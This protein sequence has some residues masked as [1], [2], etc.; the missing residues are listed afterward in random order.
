[1]KL[2]E[3]VEMVTLHNGGTIHYSQVQKKNQHHP[4]WKPKNGEM[5][6]GPVTERKGFITHVKIGNE[7]ATYQEMVNKDDSSKK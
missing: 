7:Q 6:P 2:L 3:T 4:Q 1:M 5:K